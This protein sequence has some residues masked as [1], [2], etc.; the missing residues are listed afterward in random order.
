MCRS[1]GPLFALVLGLAG[2][3]RLSAQVDDA[4]SE[5]E[6]SFAALRDAPSYRTTMTI[7]IPEESDP[8]IVFPPMVAER[9]GDRTRTEMRLEVQEMDLLVRSVVEPGRMVTRIDSEFLASMQAQQGAG[10]G[11]MGQSIVGGVMGALSGA[12]NP[13]GLIGLGIGMAA[14][15]AVQ[16]TAGET[17]QLGKWQCRAIPADDLPE[18]SV[19]S[20]EPLPDAIVDGVSMKSYRVGMTQGSE[21]TEMVVLVPAPGAPPRRMEVET[22]EGGLTID[23]SDFGTP[24]TIDI[25]PC[26]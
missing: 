15:Q 25:P 22:A 7:R 10:M 6:A 18:G 8:G 13:I 20:V 16:K 5:I 1:V 2:A 11:S 19:T 14:Q 4:R 12:F 17:F 24:I 3:T 23:Y 21:T 26:E 9:S